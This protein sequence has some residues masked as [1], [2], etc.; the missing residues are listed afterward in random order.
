MKPELSNS[1]NFLRF[2]Q[3]IHFVERVKEV[4]W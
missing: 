2:P 4:R 3:Q 1:L